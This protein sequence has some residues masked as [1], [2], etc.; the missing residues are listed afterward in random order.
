[1]TRSIQQLRGSDA[2]RAV[3]S[4]EQREG[5]ASYRHYVEN[6]PIAIH[7]NGLG[8]A[9]AG[10]RAAAGKLGQKPQGAAY[11]QLHD[12]LAAWLCRNDALAPFPGWKRDLVS[13]IMDHDMSHYLWAQEEA[14]AWLTWLKTFSQAF[15]PRE[16]DARD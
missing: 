4:M 3:R 2:L 11:R 6:L 9:V 1:M 8:Q 7:R 15:L 12:H 13:A 16:G 10:L 14:L 5:A